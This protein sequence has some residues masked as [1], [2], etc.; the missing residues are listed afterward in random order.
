[1]Q[2]RCNQQGPIFMTTRAAG[3]IKITFLAVFLSLTATNVMLHGPYRHVIIISEYW[4]N[5]YQLSFSTMMINSIH[6][7]AINHQ[8]V[9]GAVSVGAPLL[10]TEARYRTWL[11]R[12]VLSGWRR[13]VLISGRCRWWTH[14]EQPITDHHDG[15]SWWVIIINGQC[16]WMAKVEPLVG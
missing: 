13:L 11:S 4:I 9:L 6:H 3:D 12:W 1:M 5:Q 8:Q 2:P 16:C 14:G 10:A 15:N 7:Q